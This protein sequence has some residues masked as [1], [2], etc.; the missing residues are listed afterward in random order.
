MFPRVRFSY[1]YPCVWKRMVATS[2]CSV[3]IMCHILFWHFIC[4]TYEVL[5][6]RKLRHRGRHMIPL[7]MSHVQRVAAARFIPRQAPLNLFPTM[8]LSLARHWYLP[9]PFLPTSQPSFLLAMIWFLIT[10]SRL[11]LCYLSW[12]G[13]CSASLQVVLANCCSI[14]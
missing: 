5:E 2:T 1:V 8:P 11:H 3:L 13:L 10:T 9:F 6:M 14:I 4:A 12:C 7:T